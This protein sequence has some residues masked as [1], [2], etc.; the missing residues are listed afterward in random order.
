MDILVQ[1]KSRIS[2]IPDLGS[3]VAHLNWKCVYQRI[4]L[5]SKIETEGEGSRVAAVI[6]VFRFCWVF[7]YRLWE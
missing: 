1:L 3:Q 5:V 4:K 2:R 7:H 6:T